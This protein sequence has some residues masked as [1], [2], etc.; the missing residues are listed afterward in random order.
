MMCALL[1]EKREDDDGTAYYASNIISEFSDNFAGVEVLGK[2]QRKTINEGISE[3]T[4]LDDAILIRLN[5]VTETRSELVEAG[6]ILCLAPENV[7][8]A[9][10]SSFGIEDSNHLARA[11]RMI[12][13]YDPG[14]IVSSS[15]RTHK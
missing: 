5:V 11:I 9:T 7:E 8:A 14:I 3:M 2:E 15:G 10:G 4:D 6:A 1:E 13:E 12:Q